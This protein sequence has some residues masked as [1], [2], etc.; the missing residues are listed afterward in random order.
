[1]KFYVASGF[2]N[3][4]KVQ[5]FSEQL[6]QE[7]FTQTY[8]WTKNVRASTEEELEIIGEDELK[9]VRN[10]DFLVVILPGGKGTHIEMGI[11][12]GLSIPVYLYSKE[13]PE[14]TESTTFYYTSGVTRC[15]GSL[16]DLLA[17]INKKDKSHVRLQ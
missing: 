11:A 2:Q 14:P 4:A 6:K 17:L 12:L 13:F 9:A 3:K 10:A 8:D 1:M 5:Q 15:S 7:G 16:S